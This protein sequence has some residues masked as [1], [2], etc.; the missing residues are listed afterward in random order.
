MTISD[1]MIA[2]SALLATVWPKT[3]P[4]VSKLKLR[5]PYFSFRPCWIRPRCASFSVSVEIWNPLPPAT[6]RPLRR[7]ISASPKP[8][9]DSTSRT[10]D[11]SAGRPT[12]GFIRRPDQR[13]LHPRARLEVDAEVQALAADRE[14][15]DQQDHARCGEEPLRRAHEVEALPPVVRA[16]ARAEGRRVRDE[17]AA[18]HQTEDR[19]REQ[20]RRQERHE[21]ADA[22]HEREAL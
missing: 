19:L 14:R 10:P 18:A 13:G 8:A 7:W 5:V 22:E 16:L 4:I 6:S 11:S 2:M 3:G 20:H 12:A 17:A 9:V 1:A 15:A 21:R